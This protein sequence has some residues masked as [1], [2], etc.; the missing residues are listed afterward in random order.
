MEF[1][2][3]GIE[4]AFSFYCQCILFY[5]FTFLWKRCHLSWLFKALILMM[6]K[7]KMMKHVLVGETLVSCTTSQNALLSSL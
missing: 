1:S 7:M 6:M 2:V 5:S 4:R 3:N